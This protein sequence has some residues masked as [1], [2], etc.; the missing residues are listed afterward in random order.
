MQIRSPIP[1]RLAVTLLALATLAG[2]SSDVSELQ[3]WMDQ[4]RAN[5]PRKTTRIP[6]PKRFVP[7][8][9]EA[10]ADVD[11]FSNSKLQVAL[12]KLAERNRGGIKPDLNRR[13]EPLEAYPLDAIRLVGHLHKATSGS[14]ALLEADK[15]VFQA[16]MGHYIGQ[17]FGR[18]TKISETEVNVKELVQDAAG[19]WVERDTALQLQE[20]K[21]R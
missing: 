20:S 7:F 18:I 3:T 11:P 13:R 2:C 21:Q 5:A 16:K 6:E 14:V 9:Y 4:T 15:V 12:S 17:N 8:R 1:N 19:D 10:M